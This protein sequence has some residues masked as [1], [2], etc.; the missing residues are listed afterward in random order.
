MEE[1]DVVQVHVGKLLERITPLWY[2]LTKIYGRGAPH[3]RQTFLYSS[4]CSL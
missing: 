1:V 2:N 4:C 3:A